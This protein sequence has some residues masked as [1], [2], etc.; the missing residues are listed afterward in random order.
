MKAAHAN[1]KREDGVRSLFPDAGQSPQIRGKR[2]VEHDRVVSG[3]R[4]ARR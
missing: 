3:R 4:Q 2:C 1:S